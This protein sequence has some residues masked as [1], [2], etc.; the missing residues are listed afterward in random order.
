MSRRFKIKRKGTGF[1]TKYSISPEDVDSG[2]QE[3]SNQEK[4][5]ANQKYDL[6]EYIKPRSYEEF[7]KELEGGGAGSGQQQSDPVE[8]AGKA[9]LFIKRRNQ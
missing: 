4:D 5:L 9:N 6:N 3:M 1:D 8:Q 2:P 7:L